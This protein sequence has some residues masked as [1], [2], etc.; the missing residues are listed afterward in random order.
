MPPTVP[1]EA[2]A[3]RQMLSLFLEHQRPAVPVSCMSWREEPN[4]LNSAPL[5]EECLK[6][7]IQSSRI[8]RTW[9]SS[10]YARKVKMH[11]SMPSGIGTKVPFIK[12]AS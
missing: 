12:Q 4:H 7:K 8:L 10:G 6:G 5:Q 11:I 2:K 1:Q 3:H 9:D